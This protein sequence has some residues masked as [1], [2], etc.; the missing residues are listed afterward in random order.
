[1]CVEVGDER[2][3]RG[4]GPHKKHR[5][6]RLKATQLPSPGVSDRRRVC[7]VATAVAVCPTLANPTRARAAILS[8][9][10]S[11]C[12]HERCDEAEKKKNGHNKNTQ[13]KSLACA[14]ACVCV[15]VCVCACVALRNNAPTAPLTCFV[16][17]AVRK[18]M[19]DNAQLG[20]QAELCSRSHKRKLLV[21]Y[22]G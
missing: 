4:R 5:V 22:T 17:S 9:R 21:Q 3:E 1:M 20:Y 7:V 13:R 10:L 19:V 6:V 11:G 18:V 15:C 14:C 16:R 2:G 12:S 8:L